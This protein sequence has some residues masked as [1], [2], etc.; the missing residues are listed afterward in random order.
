MLKIGRSLPRFQMVSLEVFIDILLPIALWP[1][2]RL[3]LWQKWVPGVFPGGKNGR[4]VSLTFLSASWT[5]VTLSGNLNFLGSW[6]FVMKSW[7]LKFLETSGHLGPVTG[8]NY[9]I[10]CLKTNAHKIC[11]WE[12]T[13]KMEVRSWKFAVESV[14][15]DNRFS[16]MSGSAWELD[17]NYVFKGLAEKSRADNNNN[18]NKIHFLLSLAGMLLHL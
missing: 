2:G 11:C 15:R 1:W 7:N 17:W 14:I 16:L 13:L 3:S 4:W 10:F 5:T 9:L 18:N 8:L 12:R 6:V